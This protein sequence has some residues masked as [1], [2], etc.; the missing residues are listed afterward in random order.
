MTDLT[1]GLGCHELDLELSSF[2]G[3]R[4]VRMIRGPEAPPVMHSH[5]WPILSLHLIGKYEKLHD[6]GVVAISHSSAVFHPAG[7]QHANRVGDCGFEQIDIEFDPAWLKV[8]VKPMAASRLLFWMSGGT[9]ALEARKLASLAATRANESQLLNATRQFVE[10]AA[11]AETVP[12]PRWFDCVSAAL[13]SDAPPPTE[14]IAKRLS[15]NPAWLAR[16]YRR[17]TG[18]GMIETVRRKRVERA[19]ALLRYSDIP[20]AQVAVETGFCDQSHMNRCVR[21][22]LHRTPAEVRTEAQWT[23]RS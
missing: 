13:N 21:A 7:A 20:L 12:P 16:S 3:A 5:D 10:S 8:D 22:L 18:E 4:V 2:G 17:A 23:S 6:G 15:L 1:N 9:V 11:V 19:T 14:Q